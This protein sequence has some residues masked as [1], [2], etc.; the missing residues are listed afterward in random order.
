MVGEKTLGNWKS[1]WRSSESSSPE[2]RY[3]RYNHGDSG[4][5]RLETSIAMLSTVNRT[6]WDSCA[7]CDRSDMLCSTQ[8]LCSL[9][10]ELRTVWSVMLE[11]QRSGHM[12]KKKNKQT[13]K[14]RRCVA[15]LRN[16]LPDYHLKKAHLQ[17]PCNNVGRFSPLCIQL[18][19]FCIWL[20]SE[21]DPHHAL[22]LNYDH[23]N[24][25]NTTLLSSFGLHHDLISEN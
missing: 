8:I 19:A 5:P 13:K 2:W 11:T 17:T 6:T 15:A 24:N 18:I 25:K 20:Y 1:A 22:T 16:V 7:S 10:P 21:S 3:S 23:S 4:L 9:T 14:P 12:A